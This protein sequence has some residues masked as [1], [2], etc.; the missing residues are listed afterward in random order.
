MTQTRYT[1]HTNGP[2]YTA[3]YAHVEDNGWVVLERISNPAT[4]ETIPIR[5][6]LGPLAAHRLS[7]PP[8][9]VIALY[10]ETS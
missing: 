6:S 9:A 7:L 10:E 5:S 3:A 2:Q 4:G 1:L 8:T